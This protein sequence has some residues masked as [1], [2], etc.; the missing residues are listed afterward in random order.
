MAK[1]RALHLRLSN[2]FIFLGLTLG[3]AS[4]AV[5]CASSTDLGTQNGS[6]GESALGG[7]SGESALG[8]AGA[9]GGAIATGG[10]GGATSSAASKAAG[11]Q[12]TVAGGGGASSKATGGVQGRGGAAASGGATSAGAVDCGGS[13]PRAGVPDAAP[14][15]AG[16]ARADAQAPTDAGSTPRDAGAAQSPPTTGVFV[17][18]TGLDTNPG[19]LAAPLK[20]LTKAL[21]MAKTGGQIWLRGGTFAQTSTI[22]INVS[23]SAANVLKIWAY[24]GESPV[25]DFTGQTSSDGLKVS[26]NYVHI[27][28]VEVMHATHNGINI[29]GAN[30]IVDQCK[31]HDNSNSGLLI[32][33]TNAANNL[34]L[35]TD[36]YFNFDSP[37]GGDADGFSAKWEVGEGNVFRGCRAYNNSDDGWDLWMADHSVVIDDSWAFLNGTNSWKSSSFAGNGNGFKVGGNQVATPHTVTNCLAFNNTGNGGKGFDENNNLAGQTLHNCTAFGNKNGNFVFT[38]TVTSGAHVIDN[39]ISLDGKVSISSGTQKRNSWQDG[40]KVTEAD[41]LSLDTTQVLAP[42]APDGSLPTITFMHLAAGSSLI[43]A[44]VD[45]GIPFNGSAPDLGCFETP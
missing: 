30:N 45:V 33:G 38:N 23:G 25:F 14:G 39:C 22:N 12:G 35:N 21:S 16:G 7:E 29:S 3:M 26:A 10:A 41:F 19:T 43:N 42:R 5:D 6:G 4:V 9:T 40:L 32:R 17:A 28:G 18:P 1:S 15:H 11:G 31:I 36:S 34:V 20:T 44:G 24:P 27:K 13:G 37:V 8:G 2:M